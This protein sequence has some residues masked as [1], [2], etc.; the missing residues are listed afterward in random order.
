MRKIL[1]VVALAVSAVGIQNMRAEAGCGPMPV[2]TTVKTP[3]IAATLQVPYVPP[4]QG[5]IATV[6]DDQAVTGKVTMGTAKPTPLTQAVKQAYTEEIVAAD[7][8]TVTKEKVT[9]SAAHATANA[10][11]AKQDMDLPVKGKTYVIASEGGKTTFTGNGGAAVTKPE[12]AVL[13]KIGEKVGTPDRMG[14]LIGSKTFTK[15]EKVA[16]A[17][18]ELKAL[19]GPSD[20]V[21]ASNATLTLTAA[22]AK[23]ATFAMAGTFAGKQNGMDLTI[24]FTATIKVDLALSRPIDFKMTGKMSGAGDTPNGKL[25]LTGT[26]SGHRTVSYK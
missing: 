24:T 10:M 15:G 23:T 22:D 12:E 2:K 20:G 18:D 17:G 7:G 11:G 9:F 8:D 21:V 13:A 5:Q 14:K 6:V 19:T 1:F 3:K 16:L 26:V 25:A 4:K